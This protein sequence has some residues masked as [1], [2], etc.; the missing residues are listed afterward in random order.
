[1]KISY[2]NTMHLIKQLDRGTNEAYI[3][4]LNNE[5][6]LCNQYTRM[7]SFT[8]TIL[9]RIDYKRIKKKRH[10]NFLQMHKILKKYNDLTINLKSN[11]HLLYPLLV[12]QSDLRYKLLNRKIYNP[13]LWKHVLDMV[14]KDTIEYSLSKYVVLLP[15]DQRYTKEDIK[16]I[17]NIVIEEIKA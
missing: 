12:T 16:V 9:E 10:K 13:M 14:K 2:M 5:D 15:I 4:H 7:S 6:R 8:K 3:E 1:M 11:T 17:G